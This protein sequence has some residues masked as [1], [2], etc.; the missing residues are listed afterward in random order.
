M[1]IL[2]EVTDLALFWKISHSWKKKQYR[3]TAWFKR[4]K[5][6]F[7][8]CKF[9]GC[10]HDSEP[11][12]KVKEAVSNGEIEKVHYETYLGILNELKNRRERY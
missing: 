3:Q 5:K 7:G 9:R 8:K 6:Y 10:L 4:F 2:K 11:N 1:L 12:C